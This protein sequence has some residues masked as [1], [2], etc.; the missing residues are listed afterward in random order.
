MNRYLFLILSLTVYASL[1]A[2]EEDVVEHIMEGN[3]ALPTSQQPGPLFCFGQNIVDKNNF[4][5][6]G[7]VDFLKGKDQSYLQVIPSALWGVTNNFS[8]FFN[9][10]VAARFQDAGQISSGIQDIFLQGE[11]AF[12]NHDKPDHAEQATLVGALYFPTGSDKKNPPT[13]SS[14][15]S[16]FIGATFSHMSRDWYAFV[17]PGF[18]KASVHRGVPSGNKIFYQ[19]GIGKNLWYRPNKYI[20]TLIAEF[21]GEY[22]LGGAN[23]SPQFSRF[24]GGPCNVLYFGPTLWFSS[25]RF[26]FELGV[27]APIFQ[28]TCGLHNKFNYYIAANI[29][30]KFH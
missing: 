21:N 22:S 12:F 28:K 26:I 30:W 29:G 13:G 15:Y 27:T 11:W 1:Q 23:Q 9:V 18:L 2:R 10:P 5:L 7:Y 3:L 20:L 6:F 4:Q 16:G 8:L 19:A 25:Q 14:S 24:S 17:S